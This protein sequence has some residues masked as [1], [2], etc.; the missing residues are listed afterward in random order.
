MKY[1]ITEWMEV[2]EGIFYPIY[3]PEYNVPEEY[4]DDE[5]AFDG[6]LNS[7]EFLNHL[8]DNIAVRKDK[9]ARYDTIISLF[10]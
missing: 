2:E 4:Q 3:Q 6:D 5:L 7:V 9:L 8:K 1:F 10:N